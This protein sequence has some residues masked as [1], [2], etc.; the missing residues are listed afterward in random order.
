MLSPVRRVVKYGI[1]Q[2]PISGKGQAVP[3]VD[4]PDAN[5]LALVFA[6]EDVGGKPLGIRRK[7]WQKCRRGLGDLNPQVM[8]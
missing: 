5:L 7:I 1:R 3:A 2:L 6:L 4:D 8:Y